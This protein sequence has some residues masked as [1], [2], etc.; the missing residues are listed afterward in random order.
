MAEVSIAHVVHQLGTLS[1]D[2]DK[3]V[4]E[5]AT[6]EMTAVEAEGEYKLAFAKTFREA[7]G[8][9]DDRKQQAV[10]ATDALWRV[11]GKAAAMVRVQK[12]HI[13][14]LHARIDVGRTIQSTARAEMAMSQVGVT[15]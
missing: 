13:R 12:E 3:A 9:V 4:D 1:R 5:M 15:P 11:W 2:L 14:A 10:A 6:L 7:T 8:P